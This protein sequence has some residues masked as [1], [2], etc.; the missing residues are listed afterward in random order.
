[1][2]E[3]GP[4]QTANFF[5]ADNG[6]SMQKREELAMAVLDDLI[7]WAKEDDKPCVAVFDATNTTKERRNAVVERVKEGGKGRLMVIFIER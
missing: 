2:L 1:M 6:N 5:A 3:K 4:A 7:C